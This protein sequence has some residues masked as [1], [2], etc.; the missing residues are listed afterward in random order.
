MS[1]ARATAR[2]LRQQLRAHVAWLPL[3]NNFDL[4]DF[5]VFSGGVFVRLGNIANLG[6]QFDRVRSGESSFAFKSEG[7]REIRLSAGVAVGAF[8]SGDDDAALRIAFAADESLYIRT[9]DGGPRNMRS[10]CQRR[11]VPLRPEGRI[12]H[13]AVEAPLDRVLLRRRRTHHRHATRG[14][15]VH[16][17]LAGTPGTPGIINASCRKAR[18]NG[19]RSLSLDPVAPP[20]RRRHRQPVRPPGRPPRPHR[21]H[22]RQPPRRPRRRRVPEFTPGGVAFDGDD[23]LAIADIKNHILWAYE[24]K[25]HRLRVLAG[26]PGQHG[27]DR[28]R[29]PDRPLLAAHHHHPRRRPL[30]LHRHRSRQPPAPPRHPRRPRP[31]PATLTR[32]QT[33]DHRR[34]PFNYAGV[35]TQ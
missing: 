33:A 2:I 8:A 24:V 4:G 3:S 6:V 19:P 10:G 9:I 5:G 28:R 27:L 14:R 11:C 22:P 12:M 20:L 15:A 1:I 35:S 25:Q 17:V 23:L 7:T 16:E 26:A 13:A 31:V 30:R 29:R 34:R 21:Q 32:P 18:F